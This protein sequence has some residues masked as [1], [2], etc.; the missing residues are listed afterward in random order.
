MFVLQMIH[1]W[2]SAIL[3]MGCQ[4]CTYCF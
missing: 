1:C 2:K 3:M 4:R